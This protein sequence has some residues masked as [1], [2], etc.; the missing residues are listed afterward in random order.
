L[1]HSE[2]KKPHTRF[3]QSLF[4]NTI[5]YTKM[6]VLALVTDLANVKPFKIEW[7]NPS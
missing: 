4:T 2:S 5:A 6:N 7:K 1:D 3:E